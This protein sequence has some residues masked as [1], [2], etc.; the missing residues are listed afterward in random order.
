[1][2]NKRIKKV[3]VLPG[4][5]IYGISLR[6]YGSYEGVFLLLEDNNWLDDG[7]DTIL[8]PGQQL[9][10]KQPPIKPDLV[11]YYYAN[12]IYPVTEVENAEELLALI[13]DYDYRDYDSRDF[14]TN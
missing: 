6:E 3:I 5:N 13:G 9:I 1:M 11:A 2:A 10:I 4:Q 7:L 14:L 12:N 8:I